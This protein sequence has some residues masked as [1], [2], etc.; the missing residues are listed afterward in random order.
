MEQQNDGKKRRTTFLSQFDPSRYFKLDLSLFT[1]EQLHYISESVQNA[2]NKYILRHCTAGDKKRIGNETSEEPPVA[3]EW[4]D[5]G[6]WT[7]MDLKK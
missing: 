2:I 1:L 4:I 5:I 7:Q 6:L 3:D